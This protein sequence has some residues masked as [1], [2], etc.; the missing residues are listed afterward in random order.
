LTSARS[1]R[2]TN[3]RS[4][5]CTKR[6]QWTIDPKEL[7]HSCLRQGARR[8]G[9]AFG[10]CRSSRPCA[11]HDFGERRSLNTLDGPLRHK[12][13]L[14]LGQECPRSFASR[15]H[16]SAQNRGAGRTEELAAPRSVFNG[17]VSQ[18][19]LGIHA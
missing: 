17:E 3:R 6:F 8:R 5:C 9:G 16:L 12:R 10:V 7:R 18:R 15:I 19:S 4:R 2:W 14:C 1:P 13:G 11:S